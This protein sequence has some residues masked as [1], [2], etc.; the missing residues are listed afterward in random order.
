MEKYK[1]GLLETQK[2][3]IFF[4]QITYKLIYNNIKYYIIIVCIK[5]GVSV[6]MKYLYLKHSF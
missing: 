6:L 1:D 2:K 4:I 5:S 3:L